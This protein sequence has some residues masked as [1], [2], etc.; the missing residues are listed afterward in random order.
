ME[1][2][3]FGAY[4]PSLNLNFKKRHDETVVGVHKRNHEISIKDQTH[5][6]IQEVGGLEKIIAPGDKVLIKANAS[7]PRPVPEGA[8]VNTQIVYALIEEAFQA[9]AEEV[10]VGDA[11]GDKNGTIQ[12]FHD[13][14]YRPIINKTGAQLI[15]LNQPPYMRVEVP[16]AAGLA[17]KSYIFSEEL[18]QFDVLISAAKMKTH[19]EAQVTLGMKNLVGMPPVK[20][21]IGASRKVLHKSIDSENIAKNLESKEKFEDYISNKVKIEGE[22]LPNERLCRSIIDLN[23]IFPIAFTVIDGVIGMQGQGPWKG[24]A[25]ST[26][27]MLAGF[28]VLATDATAA[29]IMGF[30]PED[31]RKFQ[32]AQERELGS[33]KMKDIKLIGDDIKELIQSYAPATS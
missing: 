14:G 4:I 10:K 16:F 22:K 31:I 15:D 12:V 17:H 19:S 21:F 11:S 20:P 23:L 1:L 24:N 2:N 6:L 13:L 9:G 30:Q 28:N 33:Y 27:V 25:I 7:H 26:N 29:R 18:R 3:D 32:L 5:Q 8:V